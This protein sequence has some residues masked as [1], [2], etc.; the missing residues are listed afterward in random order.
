MRQ[1]QLVVV[2]AVALLLAGGCSD[3]PN[4]LDTYYDDPAPSAPD[5]PKAVP[6][7]SPPP[8]APVPPPAAPDRLTEALLTEADVAGEGVE[9]AAADEP[10]G[11]PGLPPAEQRRV[12]GWRYP[13]GATF[14][15]QVLAYSGDAAAVVDRVRCDDGSPMTVSVPRGADA[16]RGW[17]GPQRSGSTPCTVLLTK[18]GIVSVLWVAAASQGRS[19]DAARRLAPIAGAALDR[20]R[21]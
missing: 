5:E 11:C 18:G 6:V 1:R 19:A 7:Q 3:R 20:A 17:C 8:P 16:A 13:S 12:T 15:Q 21:P 2:S 14:T 10:S 4:D 9:R